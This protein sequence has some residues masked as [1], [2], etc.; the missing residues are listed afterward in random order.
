MELMTMVI[1]DILLEYDYAHPPEK[2]WKALTTQ[3]ALGQWLMTT[4]FEPVKGATFTFTLP[5]EP[6]YNAAQ[7]ACE[8]LVVDEPHLLSY[9]WQ[10]PGDPI[11]T[12][13]EWELTPTETGTHL[14]LEHSGFSVEAQ[15]QLRENFRAGWLE[16][17]GDLLTRWLASS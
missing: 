2:L 4:D 8:V 10:W 16:K 17:M 5:A 1:E 12:R 11:A 14:R 3:D 7:V 9:T 13:V 15:R 6:P